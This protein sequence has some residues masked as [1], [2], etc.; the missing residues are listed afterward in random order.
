MSLSSIVKQRLEH[1]SFLTMGIVAK[2]LFAVLA[3]LA[4]K[5]SVANA[6]EEYACVSY[7]K[8]VFILL[9]VICFLGTFYA[10]CFAA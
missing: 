4:A 10:S 6:R 7:W 5:L 3:V 8:D 1:T 2:P 9:L